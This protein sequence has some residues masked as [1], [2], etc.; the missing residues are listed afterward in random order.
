MQKLD[1][2]WS[3]TERLLLPTSNLWTDTILRKALEPLVTQLF[4]NET[5]QS[6][7]PPLPGP[8][9][10]HLEFT[11]HEK[12]LDSIGGQGGGERIWRKSLC[13]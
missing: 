5:F 12:I 2:P 4:T 11:R 6:S 9:P 8:C 1:P 10:I 13:V 3:I 7:T